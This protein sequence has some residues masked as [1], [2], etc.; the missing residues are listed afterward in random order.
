MRVTVAITTGLLAASAALVAVAPTTS[1]STTV[2]RSAASASL[3]IGFEQCRRGG[4]H[5]V[6]RGGYWWCEGGRYDGQRIQGG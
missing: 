5:P 4:G 6:R 3:S 1:A 2:A